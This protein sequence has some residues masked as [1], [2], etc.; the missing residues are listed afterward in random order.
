MTCAPPLEGVGG[1]TDRDGVETGAGSAADVIFEGAIAGVDLEGMGVGCALGGAT[2]GV[3][4][5]IAEVAAIVDGTGKGVDLSAAVGGAALIATGGGVGLEAVV[6]GMALVAAGGGV[7]L[8]VF[9]AGAT[10]PLISERR[11]RRKGG[12]GFFTTTFLGSVFFATFFL[13]AGCSVF[14]PDWTPWWADSFDPDDLG[15]C[16]G[17]DLGT[18]LPFFCCCCTGMLV[19][20]NCVPVG[21]CRR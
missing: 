1:E 10:S 2:G 11:L 9:G 14:A 4:L 17:L 12:G 18:C 3:A 7:A 20:I 6:V 21:E 13:G 19:S 15:S 16:V 5:G 8:G